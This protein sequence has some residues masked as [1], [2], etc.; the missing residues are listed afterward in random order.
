MIELHHFTFSPMQENTYLLIN[1]KKECIIIDPGCYF[2]NER[3]ELLQYIQTE[4]LIVTRLLNTH[5]HLDHI[6]GNK[7]VSETYK[8]RPEIHP[9][10][11]TILDLSQ[12]VGNM[13]NMPFPPSPMPGAYLTAGEIFDFGDNKIE[14]LLVPGHSPGSVAFYCAAQ[15]IIIGGDVLFRDSIGRTDLP[16]GD[17]E[18]LLNSIRTQLFVLPDDVVVYPG[19]GPATTIGYEKQHNPFL[20]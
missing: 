12:Q 10:E 1:E 3:K 11:Q 13:Y 17:H 18:T 16:G 2:E 6:F 15:K 20:N 8:V 14:I 4:G 9:N 7:L 19:H 5:C